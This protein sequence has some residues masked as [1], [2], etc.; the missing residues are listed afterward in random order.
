VSITDVGGDTLVV[1]PVKDFGAAKSRLDDTLSAIDRDLFARHCASRVVLAARGHSALVVT[2]SDDVVGWAGSLGI[3]ALRQHRSGLNGAAE[4]G[5]D[6]ARRRGHARVAIVHADLPRARSLDAVISR[7]SDV[8]IVTDHHGTGTNVLVVPADA[9]FTF[10]FGPDSRALHVAEAL[11]LGLT[12]DALQHDELSHD[13]DDAA[14]YARMMTGTD[15][16]VDHD[17]P[18][19]HDPSGQQKSGQKK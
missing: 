16:V 19:G 2:D 3:E 11:R 13:V 14:D 17:T 9:P 18:S 7:P 1:I 8:V 15:S 4:D 5:R 6:E 10:A 12:V